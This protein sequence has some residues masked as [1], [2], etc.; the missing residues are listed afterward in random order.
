MIPRVIV[1]VYIITFT[2]MTTSIISPLPPPPLREVIFDYPRQRLGGAGRNTRSVACSQSG[3]LSVGVV[4]EVFL[5]VV[6]GFVLGGL[7]WV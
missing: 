2:V 5:G 4:L 6:S 3:G 1:P 7:F